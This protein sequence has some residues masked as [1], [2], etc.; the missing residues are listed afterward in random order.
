MTNEKLAF[1]ESHKNFSVKA[2]WG[3]EPD[4]RIEIFKDGEPYKTYAYPAYRIFNIAAHFHEMV[5]N[6]IA[7]LAEEPNP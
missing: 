7:R 1:E 4:A 5:E 6:E 3:D 2:F